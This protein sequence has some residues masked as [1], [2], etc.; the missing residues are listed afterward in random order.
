MQSIIAGTNVTVDASDPANPVVSA[1]IPGGITGSGTIGTLPIWTG[2]GELGDSFLQKGDST[3]SIQTSNAA[4]SGTSSIAFGQNAQ[5]IS[6]SSVAIGTNSLAD[7]GSSPIALG[8]QAKAR[9]DSTVSIGYNTESTGR[10]STAIGAE[11]QAYALN[12]IAI[13]RARVDAIADYSVAIGGG[14]C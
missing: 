5:A 6:S 2:T 11:S 7:T 9:N 14:S 12:S 10:R 3:T 4:A 8:Y 1:S 13:G